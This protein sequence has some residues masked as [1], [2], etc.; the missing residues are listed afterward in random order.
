VK[1]FVA[2]LADPFL[3]RDS[4]S[5]PDGSDC[6]IRMIWLRVLGLEA[7]HLPL[8]RTNLGYGTVWMA[9][10]RAAVPVVRVLVW[11]NLNPYCKGRTL[12]EG[13]WEHG[14]EEDIWT[15]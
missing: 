2:K 3:A 12:I 8:I 5:L 14:A 10:V 4:A 7:S 9:P 1:C 15:Q 13:I 11:W 6:W